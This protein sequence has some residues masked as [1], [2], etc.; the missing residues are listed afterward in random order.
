MSTTE[1]FTLKFGNIPIINLRMEFNKTYAFLHSPEAEDCLK[2]PLRP[3]KVSPLIWYGMPEDLMTLLLQR[4]ILGV[5][6]YLPGALIHA[7][8]ILGIL[9]EKLYVKLR[10]P[11]SFGS[12]SAVANIYHRMPSAVHPE[13]SLKNLDQELY[14]RNVAFY[15]VVRNPIFHGQQL[16]HPEISSIREV[17]LHIAFLYEWIDHWYNPEKLWP[18]GTAF[19]GVHLRYP[20]KGGDKVP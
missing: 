19:A 4:A 8:S 12:R 16:N 9:S 13:L 17:F 6:A 7:S 2:P 18:G 11:F 15:R 20:N 5:E 1:A 10:N 14:E 3:I